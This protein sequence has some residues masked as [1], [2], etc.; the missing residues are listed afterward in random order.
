VQALGRLDLPSLA[1]DQSST[2]QLGER[3]LVGG[4]GGRARS[5]AARIV[6]KQ[7]FTGYWEYLLDEAIFTAPAHPHWGGTALIGPAGDLLGIGSL[8]LEG[9]REGGRREPLNMTVPIDLLKPILDDML[10]LG[11]PNKTARPWLGVYAMEVEGRI[12]IAGLA[13]RGPAERA[14]FHT[15]DVVLAVAGDEVRD[16]AGFYRKIWSLGPAGVEVPVK[17]W[18][19]GRTLDLKVTSGDR[20]RFLKGPS[21]H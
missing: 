19:E 10:T 15:G 20:H 7:E 16:L 11:R 3:V 12:V 8:Q 21:L 6:A 17:L 18:R 5:V 9:A 14:E 4:A 2:A 1:F 13:T